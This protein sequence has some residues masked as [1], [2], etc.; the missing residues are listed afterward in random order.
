MSVTQVKR[1]DP[2]E[3]PYLISIIYL[4]WYGIP[5]KAQPYKASFFAKVDPEA[6]LS[7]TVDLALTSLTTN[8]T[9]AHAS[10]QTHDI[11][12]E[13]KQFT[14]ILH[15]EEDAPDSN[16]V[17]SLTMEVSA[18]HDQYAWFNLISLF[19][20]TYKNRENGLRQDLAEVLADLKPKHIRIPGGSNLQG[21]YFLSIC[22]MSVRA[23]S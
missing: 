9:Y 15:P 23:R 5:V 13:W 8:K 6:H 11:T 2:L 7:G 17:L 20:P 1:N 18:D 4:G 12:T 22:S 10:F 21:N 3:D 14:A 19:P 16:N